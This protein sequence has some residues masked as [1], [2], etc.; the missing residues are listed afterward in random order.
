MFSSTK[1][2]RVELN[3]ERFGAFRSDLSRKIRNVVARDVI[4]DLGMVLDPHA[5]IN[6]DDCDFSAIFP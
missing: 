5:T 2:D 3:G 4:A 1:R 6:I